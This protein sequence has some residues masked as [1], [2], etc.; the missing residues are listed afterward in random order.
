[1]RREARIVARTVEV[2]EMRRFVSVVGFAAMMMCPMPG[3]AAT[4][5]FNTSDSRF[6]PGVDNQGYWSDVDNNTDSND[7]YFTGGV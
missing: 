3:W 5:T 4:I 6:D 7:N 2:V 1:M